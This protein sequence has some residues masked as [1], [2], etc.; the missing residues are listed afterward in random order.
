MHYLTQRE[1]VGQMGKRICSR[2]KEERK[3]ERERETERERERD[4]DYETHYEHKN[5]SN[6]AGLNVG[7]MENMY[8]IIYTKHLCCCC[9]TN[10]ASFEGYIC[11][12]IHRLVMYIH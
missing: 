7:R 2:L 3:R 1:C 12:N 9:Y 8:F 11:S 5:K 6:H 4:Y 10:E